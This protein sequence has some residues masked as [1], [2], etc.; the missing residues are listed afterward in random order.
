MRFNLKSL[1]TNILALLGILLL[2]R[3]W[4]QLLWLIQV[5]KLEFPSNDN[6][7]SIV[8]FHDNKKFS[9]AQQK[10]IIKLC[11]WKRLGLE[12]E[13]QRHLTAQQVKTFLFSRFQRHGLEL[14]HK[15]SNFLQRN[16]EKQTENNE[17]TQTQNN[18]SI[19]SMSCSFDILAKEAEL[20]ELRKPI[21]AALEQQFSNKLPYAEILADNI[22]TYNNETTAKF[23][24]CAADNT[25]YFI[26]Y[27]RTRSYFS[28]LQRQQLIH[29]ILMVVKTDQDRRSILPLLMKYN[30]LDYYPLHNTGEK[31]K[32]KST[33]YAGF[34]LRNDGSLYS[35]CNYFGTEI[36]I[37]FAWISHYTTWLLFPALAGIFV[38]LHSDN[39]SNRMNSSMISYSILIAVWST[40][41]L[42]FWKRR[43]STVSYALDVDDLSIKQQWLEPRPQF[44]GK[45]VISTITNKPILHSDDSIRYMKYCVT[46][47]ITIIAII[48]SGIFMLFC[49]WCSDL[50]QQR[51]QEGDFD[52]FGTLKDFIPTIPKIVYSI[53]VPILNH[54]YTHISTRLT[55]WE[56]HRFDSSYEHARIIKLFMFQFA[57]SYLSLFYIA[58]YHVDIIKLR[59]SLFN[60]MITVQLFSN[61]SEV[62]LPY[63]NEKYAANKQLILNKKFDDESS[64]KNQPKLTTMQFESYEQDYYKAPFVSIFDEYIKI[65]IQFGYISLFSFAWP[66]AALA[67]LISNSFELR[68]DLWKLVYSYRRPEAKLTNSI[69]GWYYVLQFISVAAVITNFS[70]LARYALLQ[71]SNP[72]NNEGLVEISSSVILESS[73]L[74]W[75]GTSKLILLIFA[76]HIIIG[77]K[78]LFAELIPDV[79]AEISN[80][81]AREEYRQRTFKF[82]EED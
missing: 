73:W 21:K 13:Q 23:N 64:G 51:H 5:K 46:F 70:F 48:L 12:N 81:Q 35:V 16:T 8:I 41:Y 38:W 44:Q 17:T 69:G 6:Y 56:N 72:Q 55:N 57:N 54:V 11:G 10:E 58:F 22:R 31:E 15:N 61:I 20:C 75:S 79:P 34:S 43:N 47:P 77:L 80:L 29:N 60:L 39:S 33:I 32:L 78:L 66:L 74:E 9:A 3:L 4:K 59:E 62:A 65:V 45:F 53:A 49:L 27:S 14:Q 1:L 82:S 7:D 28:S 42:E 36:G 68:S 30:I 71:K 63:F 19:Y 25:D 67:A 18:L 2:V 37:Y 40:L 52:H 76:E 26:N 50:L 24:R